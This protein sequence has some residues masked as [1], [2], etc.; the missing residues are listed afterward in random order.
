[1]EKT[2]YLEDISSAFGNCCCAAFTLRHGGCSKAPYDSFNLGLHVGDQEAAVLANR[3]LLSKSFGLPCVYMAQTHSTRVS[4][5]EAWTGTAVPADAL[6][7]GTPGVALAVL[8]ADCLP[9]L[10]CSADGRVVAAVH[11]GWRGVYGNICAEA[12]DLMRTLSTAPVLAYLGPC[13]RL[14]SYEVGP[15][16]C[17]KFCEVLPGAAQAFRPGKGDRMW[18]DL[19]LLCRMRLENCGVTEITDSGHDT[20]AENSR[21]FSWRRSKITGRMASIIALKN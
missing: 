8:T 11:C 14:E 10:L 15:E 13:I 3:A 19:P 7:T 1:M 6:V 17:A 21:F 16:I 9:L 20:F 4:L 18:C 12:L 5:V 2:E